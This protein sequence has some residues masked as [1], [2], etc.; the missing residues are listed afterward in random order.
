[1]L[2]VS[3]KYPRRSSISGPMSAASS[4]LSTEVENGK[5]IVDLLNEWS[6]TYVGY[7]DQWDTLTPTQKD[8]AHREHLRHF[9][10]L[11]SK[12]ADLYV[13]SDQGR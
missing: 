5:K 11:L 3:F 13:V 12:L 7:Y 10:V 8:N 9:S 1:M 2:N 4:R 6:V